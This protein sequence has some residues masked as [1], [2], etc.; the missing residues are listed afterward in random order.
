MSEKSTEKATLKLAEKAFVW[1]K[2]VHTNTVTVSGVQITYRG[3]TYREVLHLAPMDKI[4][5]DILTLRMGIINVEGLEFDGLPVVPKFEDYAIGS[6]VVKVMT[7]ESFDAIFSAN[8]QLIGH[9]TQ[10]I[11]KLTSLSEVEQGLVEIF[12][13]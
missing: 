6:H 3:L 7:D 12:R 11:V 4:E 13:S 2:G 5:G 1:K 8:L 10:A 9:L